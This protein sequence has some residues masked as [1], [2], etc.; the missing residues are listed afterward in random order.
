M[1][2]F[3]VFFTTT[4]SLLLAQSITVTGKVS[5][6]SGNALPGVNIQV[7]GTNTGTASDFDGN[8]EISAS[9]GDVLIFSFLGFKTKEVSITGATLNVNLEEDTSIL[10]EVV[11]TTAYGIKKKE[12]SLGYSVTQVKAE[13]IDLVGRTSAISALQGRVAGLQI[14]NTSGTPGGGIDILIRGMSSMNPDQNNQ[15]L[16]IIDGVSIN[17]DTFSG[18]VL[19]TEGSNAANSNEAF[20]FSSRASDINPEDIESYSVLKGAAATAL[21][22]V[23]AANG[24]VI[25]TTKKGKLGKAKINISAST[26][27]SSLTKTPDQQ[28]VFTQGWYGKPEAVYAPETATG[29]ILYD[30]RP[31]PYNF[32]PLYT[33]NSFD[34]G[35]DFIDLSNDR[36][37]DP[38][39]FFNTGVNTNFNFN[40]SGANEKIDYYFSLGN[41]KV[42]G[43]VPGTDYKKT[44]FRFNAGYQVSEKF[45]I[46]SSI[47]Y[48]NSDATKPTGG[49]KSVMSA[50][51]YWSS[52]YPVT[53][54]L[55]PDGSQRNPRASFADNPLYNIHVSSLTE[56]TNRWIGNV[57]LNWKPLEWININYTAQVDNFT[58]LSNRFV[59]PTIDVGAKV[60]GFIVDQSYNFIGLESNFIVTVNKDLNEKIHT[61]FLFGNSIL[62]NTRTYYRMYG[63]DLNLPFFNHISNTQENHIITNWERQIRQVGV[64]GEFKID[65]D[66]KLF[67]TVTGRN[68]WDSTLPKGKNSYFY[69]SI[70][71]AY[72]IHSLFG[73]NDTFTFGKLRASYAEVGNGTTYGKVG[74]FFFPD[75]NFPWGGAG[76]YLADRTI[77]DPNLKPERTKSWEIGTDLRFLNNRLRIDYAYYTNEVNDAIFPTNVA[78]SSGIISFTRN[79]GVYE[80]KGHELLVSGDIFKKENFK[81]EL[82][83]NFST[84][85]GKVISLPD[86]I[87]ELKFTD[88]Y[89]GDRIRQWPKEGD[90]IGQLYGYV[91]ENFEGQPIIHPNGQYR[92]DFDEL[93]K[94]GNVFPDF[95]MSAG[96]NFSWKNFGLNF[97]FEWK[98]GGDVR[99]FQRYTMNRTGGSEFTLQY[100]LD[101]NGN[102]NTN[103]VLD[104]VMED[105]DNPGQYIPNTHSIDM[106]P[107]GPDAL[108]AQRFFAWSTRGGR[109]SAEWNLQD[110]S[111]VKLRNISFSYDLAGNFL[112]KLNI[113][114]FRFTAS[115]SNIL[116]WTPYSGFDPESNDFGAGN[117]KYGVSGRSIP[118]TENYSIGISLGF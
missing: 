96:N 50:L 20:S 72:D 34:D 110:A 97:L 113:D 86:E 64:F 78:P 61:S 68:D 99:S 26:T 73:E 94:V 69:P 27:F 90:D 44:S 6:D 32:G 45:R 117:N 5:D 52:T 4:F 53:D 75:I 57:N 29:Y 42:E 17:N 107:N 114:K 59:P 81:W 103:L 41:N 102:P 84:T 108:E 33:D 104:G 70:S 48:T 58:N 67:L 43:I 82:I 77:A 76:G 1:L 80:T 98:K 79:S 2:S 9:Q 18:D 19:P 87:E 11:I 106:S 63:Q 105:P 74:D 47:Q 40:I 23:R 46:S 3:L 24:A 30:S 100:R 109:R 111:W 66:N 39:D 51:G 101:E 36:Y 25:I 56:D 37:Y 91:L 88:D 54:F 89:W 21:Y 65:Y 95:I 55:N 10:D 7:K 92:T 83:Y 13:D 14:S 35:T 93:V 71:L 31:G 22:G 116:I 60:N 118:L 28:K 8:Y 16:I 112:D 12:K 38:Y 62:D 49:D 15:P 115:A 85:E